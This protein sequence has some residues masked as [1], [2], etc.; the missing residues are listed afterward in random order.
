MH[1]SV[2]L[3][4]TGVMVLA[5]AFFV[6]AEFAFVKI[7]PTR[8]QQLAREG[9]VRARL[10]LGITAQ[11]PA[12]LSAS[13]LGITLASLTL[14]WLGE[15]AF[16]A[17]IRPWLEGTAASERTVHTLAVAASLT[18][19]TF[20]HTVLGE[21]A[22]KAL[23]I[24]RT[25]S[26]AMWAAVP[27]RVFYLVSFPLTWMLKAAA[28]LVLRI[29]RLPPPSEAEMLH[30]PDE[31]RLVIQHVQLDPGARRLIDRVFD[32]THRVARHVMTLRRD[33]VTLTA[34]IP[35]DD[36]LRIALANQ[37]TR[38]P[39]VEPGTDRVV[40]YIHLKDIVSALASGKRPAFMR[41]LV[42]EPIYASDDTRLEWLRREFQR[43]RV[44]IAIILGPGHTFAGIVTLEDLLEEVVGEIQDEQDAEEI[45]PIV[46]NA[47][48]SFEV[49]GRL[50][51]DVAARDIGVAF[52]AVPPE[53]ET[54]GGFIIT[55]LPEL[56][57]PGDVIAAG[58]FRFTVLAVRDRRIRRLHATRLPTAGADPEAEATTSEG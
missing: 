54:L 5:N 43:R 18:V 22:P 19:I 30:S 1:P 14:G 48:G 52:P 15:P 47:D 21:L 39:L 10:L 36:N 45:P 58:G 50:T 9:R 42:R 26:I 49:D 56:P 29:L 7:R 31:L 4:L 53:V 33:V 37:Y 3:L 13:Q 17:L 38:Y 20:L 51:L 46:R 16:A 11:L 41:E 24:Q 25:E 34:G 2:A 44:H 8:L 55:Q 12:Y 6:A 28:G 57:V 40:G 32:Y 23:A 27:F 35:F